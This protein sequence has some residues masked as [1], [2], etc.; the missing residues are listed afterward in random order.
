M[1]PRVRLRNT[2][3]FVL[4]LLLGAPI[5][6]RA[7]VDQGIV[8]PPHVRP[9]S[10]D[11]LA[12]DGTPTPG[13]IALLRAHAGGRLVRL[14]IGASQFERRDVRFDSAGVSWAHPAP[15]SVKDATVAD[16]TFAWGAIDRIETR[17]SSFWRGVVVGAL[18]GT[19]LGLAGSS[20]AG[21]DPGPGIIV[22]LAFPPAGAVLG[23]ILGTAFPHWRHEWPPARPVRTR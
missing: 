10:L 17:R 13:G 20:S 19:V 14:S 4:M 12:A 22:F 5:A 16:T 11:S 1:A 9:T 8:A 18:V 2:I 15:G 3:S 6:T 7:Q 23:G 21:S